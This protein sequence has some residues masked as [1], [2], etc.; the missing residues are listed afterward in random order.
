[1]PRQD[2]QINVQQEGREKW[3]S[4]REDYE[5]DQQT[6]GMET[7]GQDCFSRLCLSEVSDWDLGAARDACCLGLIGV[8][9][10]AECKEP[11]QGRGK[12]SQPGGDTVIV[13]ARG[14]WGQNRSLESLR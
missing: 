10:V 9:L 8:N 2:L 7:T 11:G 1:M 5:V 13:Q 12:G 4:V 3:R 6:E 14:W